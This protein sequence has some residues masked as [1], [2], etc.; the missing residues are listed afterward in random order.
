LGLGMGGWVG[1]KFGTG[2]R[3][4]AKTDPF[5]NQKQTGKVCVRFSDGRMRVIGKQ[6]GKRTLTPPGWVPR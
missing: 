2:G 6:V 1:G 5:R 3:G 4:K